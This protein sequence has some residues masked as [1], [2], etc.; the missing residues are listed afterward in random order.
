MNI[1]MSQIEIIY[2]NEGLDKISHGFCKILI[3]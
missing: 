1:P 2:Y 3:S